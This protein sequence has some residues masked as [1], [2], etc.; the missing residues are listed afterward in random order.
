MALSWVFKGDESLRLDRLV[1]EHR[2]M[3]TPDSWDSADIKAGIVAGKI[4]RQTSLMN[5]KGNTPPFDN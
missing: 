1:E 5:L 4:F 3:G 2:L